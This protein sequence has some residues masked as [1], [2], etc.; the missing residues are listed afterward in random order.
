[1]P[2]YHRFIKLVTGGRASGSASASITPQDKYVWAWSRSIHKQIASK[3]RHNRRCGSAV[4]CR[5]LQFAFAT[6]W[7]DLN[8]NAS[9]LAHSSD[10]SD[11]L[12][13]LQALLFSIANATRLSKTNICVQNCT[14]IRMLRRR[15]AYSANGTLLRESERETLCHSGATNWFQCEIRVFLAILD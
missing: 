5:A 3:D 1:V 6:E 15:A 4:R 11:V 7:R 2:R 9:M 13:L 12:D 14:R 10:R 8:C